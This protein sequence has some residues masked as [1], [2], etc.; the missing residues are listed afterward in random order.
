MSLTP[1]QVV[2]ALKSS[3]RLGKVVMAVELVEYLYLLLVTLLVG[4][5]V[6]L[7]FPVV[8]PATEVTVSVPAPEAI[9]NPLQIRL[10]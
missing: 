8:A 3:P 4:L 2:Q 7:V 10:H 9:E 1:F 6:I 5:T